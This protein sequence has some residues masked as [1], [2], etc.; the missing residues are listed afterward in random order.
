MISMNEYLAKLP[1]E[2]VND[3]SIAL[4][5]L[6]GEQIA[7]L[8]NQ[9]DA[10]V[11]L[12][13]EKA[14]PVIGKAID[15]IALRFAK[16]GRLFYIGAGTS[17]R[18]GV[19]D[20]SEC[21]PTFGVPSSMVQGIIAGGD[22]A[23][24]YSVEG[25]EDS[26][27]QGKQDLVCRE[28]NTTDTVVSISASGYAPYCCAALD[29][30]RSIGVL[31]IALSC[32]EHTELS[33]HADLAIEAP[34]GAEVLMGSTRLKAGTATKMILN[35]LSTGV[36]VRTGRVYRNLM[37]DLSVSNKK[38]TDRATRIVCHATGVGPEQARKLLEKTEG[39]VK[40]AIVMK[41]TDVSARRA[42]AALCEAEGWVSV[43][44]EKLRNAV[45]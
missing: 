44:I 41:M 20:A 19:L 18:L 33:A 17:G 10:Q 4:D 26:Q 35:M 15:E 24:R 7:R 8:M 40:A 42:Q 16:G 21:P 12:A 45:S 25:A 43:A 1:T 39:S 5:T 36:M 6:N 14:L 29:Y 37:V 11:T 34:T 23:L 3:Q 28:L 38:L 32:N 13:V 22:R 30:A 2:Q 9:Q 31:A 27:T